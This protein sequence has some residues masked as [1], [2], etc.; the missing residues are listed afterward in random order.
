MGKFLVRATIILVA[1]YFIIAYFVAQFC[2][3]DIL[4]GN[5]A[6]LFELCVVV[7]CY[8]E[9]KYHCRF[10]KYTALAIFFVELLTR[11]DN[12]IDF[13][14]IEQHNLIPIAILA[15]GIGTSTTLAFHHFYKVNQLKSK[16]K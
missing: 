15:I 9:G 6:L 1:V 10:M 3:V 2:Y 8:S 16:R 5:H 14:S 11:L 12:A 4:M 7:Y 13:L